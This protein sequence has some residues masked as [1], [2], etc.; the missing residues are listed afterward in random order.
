[1]NKQDKLNELHEQFKKLSESQNYNE[2]IELRLEQQLYTGQTNYYTVQQANCYALANQ[3]EY[4]LGKINDAFESD[5]YDLHDK[6]ESE[7]NI[8]VNFG[9]SSYE[10]DL[11]NMDNFD[12]FLMFL[13]KVIT[14]SLE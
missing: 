10:I 11:S 3:L 13:K 1:M 4:H 8:V 9:K 7:L 6:L 5:N 2:L 14:N 12:S